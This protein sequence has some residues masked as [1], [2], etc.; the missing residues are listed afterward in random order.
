MWLVKVFECFEIYLVEAKFSRAR[1]VH[2]SAQFLRELRR[3]LVSAEAQKSSQRLA[4]ARRE[5]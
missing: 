1:S 5:V 3:S 4:V 2:N